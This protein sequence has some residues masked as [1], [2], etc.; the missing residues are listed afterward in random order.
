MYKNITKAAAISLINDYIG[1]KVAYWERFK[2]TMYTYTR[3]ATDGLVGTAFYQEEGDTGGNTA[4]AL[5]H[6][7]DGLLPSTMAT[8]EFDGELINI[9]SVAWHTVNS[10]RKPYTS[11]MQIVWTQQ[12][13][14]E[15]TNLNGYLDAMFLANKAAYE[16][17]KTISN[18][19]NRLGMA[20]TTTT[21][22]VIRAM[23]TAKWLMRYDPPQY[24]AG[25]VVAT[26]VVNQ[27]NPSQ[28]D[29]ALQVE[30]ENEAIEVVRTHIEV[31]PTTPVPG[32]PDNASNR[33]VGAQFP[34]YANTFSIT[35]DL[36]NRAAYSMLGGG[37]YRIKAW[38][39]VREN[40]G[41]DYGVFTE[42]L[43]GLEE[44]NP[45]LEG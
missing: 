27:P 4:Q 38:A 24:A 41:D 36:R 19:R 12:G 29:V 42:T 9:T 21:E 8:L 17:N 11:T 45:L 7:L 31:W 40:D 34:Y 3:S 32:L 39:T 2:R 5:Q 10:V 25:D 23:A 15:V 6:K 22:E 26:L 37:P 1:S 16:S 43:V 35:T 33:N 14:M 28:A 18:A 30:F 20:T 44:K 13:A